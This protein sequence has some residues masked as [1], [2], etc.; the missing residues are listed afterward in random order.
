MIYIC[1]MVIFAY[2]AA[3]T[4]RTTGNLSK[5]GFQSFNLLIWIVAAFMIGLI[6]LRVD[7]N[8]TAAYISNFDT[9]GTVSDLF[10]E[11]GALSW[12]KNPL[13]VL[14]TACM[15][16]LS[17]NY[18][19]YFMVSAVFIVLSF[20][21]FLMQEC[22]KDML[23]YSL[24]LY[25][26]FGTYFFSLAAMK[27][28]IAMAILTYAVVALQ[29]KQHIRFVL[30]VVVAG[31][32]HTYA[33]L[34]LIILLFDSKPW[35]FKTYVL[36]VATLIIMVTFE[37]TLTAILQYADS[38][39][40]DVAEEGLFNGAAMNTLRI[41]VYGIAPAIFWVGNR[42]LEPEMEKKHYILVHMSI[43]SFLFVLLGSVS[44][45]NLFGRMARYFEVGTIVMLPWSI[46][47]IFNE[48]SAR[49][50]YITMVGLFFMFFVYD[51]QGFD[52]LYQ[53]ITFFQFLRG[54]I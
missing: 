49:F 31:L 24:F 29:R 4:V 34:F 30:I 35:R 11:P 6:G 20:L 52:S 1:S 3:L 36:I 39:G 40:K 23:P 26:T 43:F 17:N 7:Y 15:K 32:F 45:A 28:S 14:Y 12:T 50:I 21:K 53:G 16:S 9:M 25:F 33:F 54:V 2:V 47:R 22:E 19:V 51:Y 41:A 44:G 48:R 46:K 8:D 18:H 13:F 10:N 37:S 27:Q 38:I 42:Y 5:S